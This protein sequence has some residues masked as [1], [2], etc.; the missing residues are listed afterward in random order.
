MTMQTR[1]SVTNLFLQW[2]RLEPDVLPEMLSEWLCSR[3]LLPESGGLEAEITGAAGARN[4]DG[5]PPF[6]FETL[7]SPV[8]DERNVDEEFPEVDIAPDKVRLSLTVISPPS[9]R[10]QVPGFVKSSVN[11]CAA[12]GAAAGAAAGAGEREKRLR[13]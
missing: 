2:H 10:K 12:T 9:F 7:P 3:H 5:D 13:G 4:I 11:G 8:I 1:K 6:P